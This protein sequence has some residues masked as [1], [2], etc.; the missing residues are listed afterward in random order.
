[1][2][3]KAK[4]VNKFEK[5]QQQLT[6]S[7]KK[8]YS[9]YIS[10]IICFL[11]AFVLYSNTFKHSYVLDDGGI[12]TDNKVV[13]K[14]VQSIPTIL[15]TTYW[16]GSTNVLDTYRPLT[17]IMFAI[18]WQISPNN[19]SLSHFLNVLFY[20]LSCLLLFI[21]L[22][23][24]LSKVHILV[25]LIITLLF[26]AHPIHT[27]VVAN[28]KSRDEIMSFFF[29]MLTLLFLHKWFTKTKWWGL[30]FSLL[31]YFLSFMSKEGVITMLFLFPLLGWYFTEA[32]PKTLLIG[33][34][35]LI[36]P[37]LVYIIIR[38][39]VLSMSDESYSIDL[40]EN[41]LIGAPDSISHFATAVMLLGKYLLLL[42]APYQLV[43]DYSYNQIPIV[44]LGAVGFIL[45]LL[46]YISL[47]I[48]TILNIR[49][50]SPLIFGLL[51]FLI[52]ISIYSNIVFKITASFGER[53]MFLPSLGLCIAFVFFIT[54][55]L[56]V[57]IYIKI[58]SV[59]KVLRSKLIF[60]SILIIVITLFSLKTFVRAAEWKNRT[61][62]YSND[63]KRSPNSV[64]MCMWYGS[65][66]LNNALKEEDISKKDS[67]LYQ[68]VTQFE[69]G[70]SIY[71]IYVE[72]NEQLSVAWYQL[73]D[74]QKALY[75]ADKALKQNPSKATTWY[76]TSI[77]YYGLGDYQKALEYNQKAISINP[78]YS[79]AYFNIGGIMAVLK[80]YDEA[81]VQYKKCIQYNQ[82]NI[83]AYQ[84]IGLCYQYLNNIEEA[85]IWFE[86]ARTLE[87]NK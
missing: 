21:V 56:K 33:S 58:H 45:S 57:D 71:P 86:K 11:F 84:Y 67:Y 81:I 26:A 37:A 53:L 4:K 77:I 76:N 54:Q 60:T 1:M 24:Y 85:N 48:Y 39:Q 69:R 23:K 22:Y 55:L 7:V 31:M 34:L 16:N 15:K 6:V 5:N 44:G 18:E 79:D 59:F 2:S 32:K 12:I 75:Y 36:L 83:K 68:A 64:Q 27:E 78:A 62:L 87:Q 41:F 82:A 19:P 52:T 35:L 49:K 47:A 63:I 42:V 9:L 20:A 38:H 50:K 10:A 46:I 72:C 25:P 29:L 43:S 66:L 8:S 73:N 40:I 30:L 13:T 65:S 17:K 61:V 28:I 14:G 80:K 3:S 70:L 74:M 51:F